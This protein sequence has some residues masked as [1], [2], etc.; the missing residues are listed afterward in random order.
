MMFIWFLSGVFLGAYNVKQQLSIALQVQPQCFCVLAAI[1]TAQSLRYDQGRGRVLC[2]VG[3]VVACVLAGAVEVGFYYAAKADSSNR[4]TTAL[5]AL[6]AMLI[7]LGLLP[8]YW[9]VYQY[10]AVIGISLLFLLVDLL[11]GLFSVLSLIWTAGDFDTV[12]SISYAAVVVLE[13]GI[14]ALVPILN[15]RYHR[16]QEQK[17]LEAQCETTA[18]ELS[19]AN[20]VT[21]ETKKAADDGP[22][23]GY[24]TLAGLAENREHR[25]GTGQQ[26]RAEGP[27]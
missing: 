8:Q 15:P 17:A 13:L 26:R 14:F 20:H 27:Q 22:E 5:G 9:E 10:R 25:E 23:G 12:A 18:I 6:A 1:A 21:L 19:N 16:A 2:I 24:G 11:G 7:V 4:F 3:C